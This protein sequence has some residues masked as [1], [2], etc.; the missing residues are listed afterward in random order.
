MSLMNNAKYSII[1]IVALI[2]FSKATEVNDR[3]TLQCFFFV[4]MERFLGMTSSSIQSIIPE[5]IQ[6][7]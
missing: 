2:N 3:Y 7:R 1:D 6:N 5:K 4:F